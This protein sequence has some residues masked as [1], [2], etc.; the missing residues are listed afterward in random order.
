M[1]CLLMADFLTGFV[2]S[3][4]AHLIESAAALFI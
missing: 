4:D 1:A 3:Q 2:L